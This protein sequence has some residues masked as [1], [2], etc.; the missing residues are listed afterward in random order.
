MDYKVYK[1][2]GGV[3][4]V[5]Y[6]C[7]KC[8]ATIESKLA[9]AGSQDTCPDCGAG[10]TV[11]GAPDLAAL[12]ER[13]RQQADEAAARKAE[14]ARLQ[15]IRKEEKARQLELRRAEQE[16]ETNQHIEQQQIESEQN[17]P[18]TTNGPGWIVTGVVATVVLCF[19]AVIMSF[20]LPETTGGLA[21][22]FTYVGQKGEHEAYQNTME[23]YALDGLPFDLET[24]R[25]FCKAK[26]TTATAAGF[27]FLVVFDQSANAAFPASPFTAM[28]GLEEDKMKHII[29]VYTYNRMNG[30]SELTSYTPNMWEGKPITEKL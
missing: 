19:I 10:F 18:T 24:L 9:D 12:R 8:S 13:E 26:K 15:Q 20:G 21:P 22:P 6:N 1:A 30:F 28:Y 17:G 14:N 4:W 2:L 25:Q 11:P 16:Q 29:A 7:P 23:L 27:T 5:K 3:H